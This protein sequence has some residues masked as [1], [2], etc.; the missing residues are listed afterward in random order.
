MKSFALALAPALPL[1]ALTGIAA[2]TAQPAPQIPGQRDASRVAAGTYTID[3]AHTQVGWRVSHFGFNDYLGLFGDAKGTLRLDPRN[4]AAT[5]LDV[6]LPVTSVAVSS[7]GLR[8]HLLRPGKDGGKPDFFGAA[9][10]DARFVSTAVRRTGPTR[11]DVTGNFTL[12]GVTRPVTIA[13]EFVGA[14]ANPMNKRGTVGFH[15]RTAIKR[16]DFGLSYALPMIADR[17]E[18]D[19]SVAFERA[20]ESAADTRDTCG[21]EAAGA[22]IGRKDTAA[23]RSEVAEAAGHD[24]IRWIAPGTMVTQDRREDRL[25][26]D[27]DDGGVVTRVRCG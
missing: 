27:L 7:A 2:A 18:L 12:N 13:A 15:G 17:V 26:V 3:G 5:S 21:A 8:E 11:A 24:R 20:G 6:T 4:L 9:P 16:S 14:G 10:A 22:M 23:L 19:I 25:N 1:L